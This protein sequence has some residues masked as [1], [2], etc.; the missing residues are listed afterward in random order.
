MIMRATQ[1]NRI[2]YAVFCLKKKKKTSASRVFSGQP[3]VVKGNRPEE[4]Q[5]SSTSVSCSS[6]AEPHFGHLAGVSRATITSSQSPQCHTGIR[7][8]HHSCREIVQSW[9]LYIQFK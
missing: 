4:N 6:F 2:S 9:M 3:N 5:V 7:C 1:K 8:P